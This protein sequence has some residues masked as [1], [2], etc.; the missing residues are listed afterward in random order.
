[1]KKVFH[2]IIWI[3]GGA[4]TLAIVGIG[5]F[6]FNNMTYFERDMAAVWRAGFVEKQ[7]MINGSSLNYAEGP[8]NG[9]IL[10]LIH[11]Q[12]VDWKSYAK[13]LPKLSKQYHVFAIDC[14]GHGNSARV[15]EKYSTVAM[16]TD[17]SIFIEKVIGE[18]VVVSGHSSGGL[19]AAWLA[20]NK[21]DL[22]Q[23]VVLEDP[24]FF[25]SVLPRAEKSWNYVDLATTAHNFLESGETDFVSY[26][27][28]H[29]K[30]I[31]LFKDLQPKL[32]ADVLEYRAKHPDEAVKIYYMP[33][34]MNEIF[35]GLNTYDPRFGDTFYTDSW[36]T[37]FDHAETLAN[38]QVP[39][40]LIHTNWSYNADGILMAAMDD[41][42]AEQA[43]SLINGVQFFKV[44]SGHGFH[45]EKPGEF[46]QILLDFKKQIH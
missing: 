23:G 5:G 7:V 18:P 24:P 1:M 27:I 29:G 20:A 25:T 13:V 35:R 10:L 15:P 16:G 41:K 45:F 38:I 3:L 9:P 32:T 12:A 34:I 37:G 40:V 46:I 11:G 42:D 36:N 6:I 33:P 30:F 26:N 2:M 17:I 31:M 21:P 44:D 28:I 19:L 39:A 22:V 14:Y 43:H 4:L 8:N